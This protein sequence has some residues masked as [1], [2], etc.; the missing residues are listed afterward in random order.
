MG[1]SVEGS[2]RVGLEPGGRIPMDS[3][4]C[5]DRQG[6][7]ELDCGAVPLARS[8]STAVQGAHERNLQVISTQVTKHR[9]D[10]LGVIHKKN[11][12]NERI[13]Y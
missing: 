13:S 8:K 3:S 12:E 6:S 10:T 11:R 4:H 5:D 7:E 2:L 9:R 1:P